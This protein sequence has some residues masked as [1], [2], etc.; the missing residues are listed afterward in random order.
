MSNVDINVDRRTDG[1]TDGRTDWRTDGR[2][3]GRLYRTLLQAGA[4]KST[5]TSGMYSH[6]SLVPVTSVFYKD[7]HLLNLDWDIGKQYRPR[8]DRCH[9]MWLLTSVCPVDLNYRQLK[10]KWNS[11]RPHSGPFSQPTLRDT[12]PPVLSVLWLSGAMN[13]S[14]TNFLWYRVQLL[15]A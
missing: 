9:R 7:S 1:L 3:I 14:L 11:L 5:L 6:A 12:D 2:K 8:S 10:V 13:A 15:K 4:I